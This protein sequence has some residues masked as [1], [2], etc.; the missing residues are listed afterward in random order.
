VSAYRSFSLAPQS[1]R[2]NPGIPT[3]PSKLEMNIDAHGGAEIQIKIFEPQ[4]PVRSP[5]R[6][7]PGWLRV[8]KPKDR[9]V[10][11]DWNLFRAL[12]W[13]VY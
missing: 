1:G 13:R 10:E 8:R 11:G 2:K 3:R 7:A 6:R 12:R 5:R 9:E 4:K